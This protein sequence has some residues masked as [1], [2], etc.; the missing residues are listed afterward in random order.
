M[1]KSIIFSG[2]CLIAGTTI[3]ATVLVL[4][5]AVVG[6]NFAQVLALYVC[7]WLLMT[8]TGL[9]MAEVCIKMPAG[10]SFLSLIGHYW[11]DFGK[12]AMSFVFYLLMF[13][14]LCSYLNILGHNSQGSFE[15]LGFHY[16]ADVWIGLWVLVLTILMMIG[17]HILQELNAGFVVIMLIGFV[18]LYVIIMP[19]C[20]F[21]NLMHLQET[22]SMTVEGPMSLLFL[23]NAFGFHIIIPTVRNSLGEDNLGGIYQI[24]W[25]GAII[26]LILYLLW[27]VVSISLLPIEFINSNATQIPLERW[28]LLITD[29]IKQV[30]DSN[31]IYFALVLLHFTFVL[32]SII[33]ISLALY[34][35]IADFFQTRGI[36]Q[37]HAL[38]VTL[39]LVPS[40]LFVH[41][42]TKGIRAFLYYAGVLVILLNVILPALLLAQERSN[43][44]YMKFYQAV[45]TWL[46]YI[47]IILGIALFYIQ[48]IDLK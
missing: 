4:I 6:Y 25:L 35:L 32:T 22:Y 39:S 15:K 29:T 5:G 47:V 7:A 38:L 3:G 9:M 19:H 45:P 14:L 31:I 2:A 37:I 46:I 48:L 33:G 12:W 20:H 17:R 23:I 44:P 10:H 21:S 18:V 11:G 8:I 42:E 13:F 26:P 30:S 24:I 41:F 36:K 40:Y 27:Y 1:N 16:S 34:D 28:G 43:R